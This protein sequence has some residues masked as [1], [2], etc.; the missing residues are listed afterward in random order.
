MGSLIRL[1]KVIQVPDGALGSRQ[2]GFRTIN[3][4]PNPV[5]DPAPLGG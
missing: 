5:T 3:G 4:H 2:I 1:S